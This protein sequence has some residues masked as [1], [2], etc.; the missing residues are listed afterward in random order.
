MQSRRWPGSGDDDHWTG[1]KGNDVHQ[2]IWKN[3]VVP[4]LLAA[5]D[6]VP[7]TKRCTGG[8]P[9]A[10]AQKTKSRT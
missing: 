7:D 4:D 10:E 3:D 2:Q 1:F 9:S 6:S 5:F 8:A